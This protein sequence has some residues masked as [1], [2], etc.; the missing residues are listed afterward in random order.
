METKREKIYLSGPITGVENLNREAFE[1]AESFYSA[2]GYE[3][4]NPLKIRGN[5]DTT[6][7]WSHYM[8]NDIK[9]LVDCNIVVFLRGWEVSRG[10]SLEMIIATSLELTIIEHES[11]KSTWLP[12][13]V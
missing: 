2:L 9:A 11:I 3:V 13:Y 8:R 1:D 12:D 4:I 6:K 7:E 5:E 10:A